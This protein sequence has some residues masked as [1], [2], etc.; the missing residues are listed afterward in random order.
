MKP[1][2]DKK[3]IILEVNISGTNKIWAESE[4]G[5]GTKFHFILP[6]NQREIKNKS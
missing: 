5:K 3:G 1:A 2:A 6:V 4:Y